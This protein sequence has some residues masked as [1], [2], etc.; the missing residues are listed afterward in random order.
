MNSILIHP[1]YFPSIAQ[2]VVIAKAKEIVFEVCDNYQKQT[3]RNRSYIAHSN[4]KL[5]LSVPVK[6]DKKGNRQKMKDVETEN[7]FA[8]QSH[9]WKSIQTA[10]RTSPFFEYY[11]DDLDL[12]FSKPVTSLLRHNL[13][14]QKIL[15]DLMGI[16][17][18]TSFTEAYEVQPQHITDYRFLINVKKEPKYTLLPYTQVLA[19]NHDFLSNLSVLDLLFNEG[20]NTL[21]YL[22]N[23]A[24]F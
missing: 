10:Y 8:W 21:S 4:G 23:Q 5:L 14:I 7:D 20:P 6:H 19:A 2:M 1:A 17:T 22:E 16:S 3:Y 24:L 18:K 15:F 13:E 11:E 9:H 12:L